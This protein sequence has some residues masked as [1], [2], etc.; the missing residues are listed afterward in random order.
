MAEEGK[1]DNARPKNTSNRAS[2]ALD[3]DSFIAVAEK[4]R[5]SMFLFMSSLICSARP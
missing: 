4:S 5:L 2:F 1:I 3:F